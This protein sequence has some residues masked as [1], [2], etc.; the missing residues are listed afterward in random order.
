MQN[1]PVYSNISII[2]RAFR[3]FG[4]PLHIDLIVDYVRTNWENGRGISADLALNYVKYPLEAHFYYKKGE[5][6][7]HFIRKESLCENLNEL[8]EQMRWNP[9]PWLFS[10]K[11]VPVSLN[12]IYIDPRFDLLSS[13]GGKIYLI[14]SYWNLLNDLVYQYM[15][16]NNIDKISISDIYHD[17]LTK[18]AIDD[19]NAHFFPKIDPRYKVDRKNTVTLVHKNLIDETSAQITEYIKETI[20]IQTP[21]IKNFLIERGEAVNLREIL[22]HVFKIQPHFSLFNAY[23]E[24]VKQ[25]LNLN[26]Q[27]FL[28][29]EDSLIYSEDHPENSP[30]KIRIQGNYTDF[31]ALSEKISHL[32]VGKEQLISQPT[33][34]LNHRTS[35]KERTSLSYTLRYFDRIQETLTGHYFQDWIED[36]HLNLHFIHEEQE[37]PLVF[38][39][40]QKQNILFGDSLSNFMIDYD[41]EPGQ[42]LEFEKINK[43]LVMS[44]GNFDEASHTEQMKYEDIARLSEVKHYGTKSLLQNLAELLMLHPSGLHIRQIVKEI[45][46]ETSYTE[47][48]IRGTLSSYPFFNTITGKIGF[49]RF[50]PKQWK[51]AYMEI[52]IETKKNPQ[53]DDKKELNHKKTLLPLQEIFKK[54]AYA[55]R[56]NRRRLQNHQYNI[57]PKQAFIELAWEYYAFIIYTYAKNNKGDFIQLEDLYQQ[58]YFALLKAYE[59]YN[60]QPGNSFYHYFKR[61]LSAFVRRYK[62]NNSGLIRIP[63]HRYEKLLKLDKEISSDLLLNGNASINSSDAFDYTLF[64]TNWISLEDVHLRN[65]Y[66]YDDEYNAYVYSY[67]ADPIYLDKAMPRNRVVNTITEDWDVFTEDQNFEETILNKLLANQALNYL[68]RNVKSAR[69]YE[70]ILYRYGFITGEEM[71]LQEVADIYGITRE[72]VRQ[73]ESKG[74]AILKQCKSIKGEGAYL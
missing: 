61:Y 6:E 17:I 41:L 57:L 16:K 8:H 3:T 42:K 15:T 20:A 11:T 73:L 38:H 65:N 12:E 54:K 31:K 68:K 53:E 59:N 37:I 29:G 14:L 1:G 35:T 22:Q 24:G 30:E 33:D 26:K 23:Y 69:D 52:P 71:T 63:V 55:T 7:D 44:L 56:K 5:E 50:N 4:S 28:V 13:D 19:E 10:T 9:N 72:R 67:F 49:W 27:I 74:L 34:Q 39:Y 25:S 47:S 66:T 51:K 70:V 43:G 2:N 64:K 21:R 58:A 45:Q 46:G 62:I 32:P 40:D 36:N 48:S 18:Y 60:P